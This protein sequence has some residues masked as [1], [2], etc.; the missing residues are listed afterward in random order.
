MPALNQVIDHTLLDPAATQVDVDRIIREAIEHHFC[1]VM[2]NPYWTAYAAAQ[3]KGTGVNTDAVIGFPLGANTTAI[4]VAEAQ[5]A[6][7]D[8]ADEVDVVMNIGEF[9]GGHPAIVRQDLTAVVT[10]VHA[11]HKLVKVIIETALLTDDQIMQAAELVADTG[12]DFVKTST[13]FAS[14]G[15]SLH[16]VLLMKRAVGDR[17]KVKAS[18]GVHTTAEAEDMLAVGAQRL[19]TSAGMAVI[20]QAPHH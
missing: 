16:D 2:L 5:Q 7:A 10:A 6:L 3:L 12:A 14:R 18:G 4:K 8:G 20:G 13:G 17:I 15:A 19:G 9:L 1:S 11:Q